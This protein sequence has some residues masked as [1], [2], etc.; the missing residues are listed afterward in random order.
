MVDV[1]STEVLNRV[2]DNMVDRTSFLTDT[3][4][5][6]VDVQ[7]GETIL[8]DTTN[9]R[10]LVTPFVH[11]KAEAPIIADQGY[12]TDSFRPAYAKDKRLFDP[13]KG[14]KRLPGEKIGGELTPAQ[15]IDRAIK[16]NLG[17]QI[18]MLGLRQEIMAGEVL[19]TGKLTIT[20]ERYPTTVVDFKRRAQN[21]V[22]LAG[23]PDAWG[24]VGAAR[25]PYDSLD[26]EAQ[27]LSDATGFGATDVVFGIEA[28]KLYKA[29]LLTD[30]HKDEFDKTLTNLQMSEVARS[31]VLQPRDGV[32]YRGRVGYL[33]L[34]TYSG[35]YTDPEDMVTKDIIDPYAVIIGNASALDGVRHFGAIKDFDN[36]GLQARQY[37]VKSRTIFDPSGLEFL[38]QSAPLLVPYRRNNVKCLIVGA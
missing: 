8:F 7:D 6:S 23:G 19:S 10:K 2:V 36:N 31:Y 14:T 16:A 12:E 21:T 30:A 32:V 5:P 3:F 13:N 33:R 26:Y 11:P 15:R 9:G 38:M 35:T 18:E 25:K 22:I 29:D 34:W 28:W 17:E 4:F 24:A 1:F 20:G 37:F 27:E